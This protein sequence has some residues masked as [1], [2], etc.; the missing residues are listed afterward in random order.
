MLLVRRPFHSGLWCMP[1]SPPLPGT[2]HYIILD[3]PE[4][5]RQNHVG[6]AWGGQDMAL[7]F[8]VSV[9]ISQR[10]AGLLHLCTSCYVCCLDL[11]SLPDLPKL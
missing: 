11:G 8:V 1:A 2:W 4:K 3:S 10:K 9:Y 5:Q 7:N 6:Q